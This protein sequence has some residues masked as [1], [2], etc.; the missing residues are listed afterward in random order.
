V[1]ANVGQSTKQLKTSSYEG[2]KERKLP[3]VDYKSRV[4]KELVGIDI[5]LQ[6]QDGIPKKLRDK[7]VKYA[8]AQLNL[9]LITNRVC[10][11]LG[12]T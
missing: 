2:I 5:L 1:I 8:T 11:K 3:V 6:W 4:K 12:L 10:M 9:K 7:I